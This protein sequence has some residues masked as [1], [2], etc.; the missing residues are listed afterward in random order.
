MGGLPVVRSNGARKSSQRLYAGQPRT[1]SSCS[2]TQV[3]QSECS[4]TWAS[5]TTHTSKAQSTSGISPRGE[6]KTVE[7]PFAAKDLQRHPFTWGCQNARG[8]IYLWSN[9]QGR[10][11][12][13]RR[14]ASRGRTSTMAHDIFREFYPDVAI[15]A[16]GFDGNELTQFGKREN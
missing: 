1:R 7:L 12:I 16:T 8:T 2:R 4:T 6:R 13:G 11:R 14:R 9:D 5:K 15:P 3:R 10:R